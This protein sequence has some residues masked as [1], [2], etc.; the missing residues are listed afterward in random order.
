MKDSKRSFSTIFSDYDFYLLGEGK[1]LKSYEKLG[2]HRREI[3][4]I[5]GVNFA[6]WAPNA[7]AASVVGSFNDW[8]REANPMHKHYP[9]GIWETFIPGI[10]VGALYKYSIET[11]EGISE[12][13]DPVGFYAEVPPHNASTFVELDNYQWGDDEWLRE[14]QESASSWGEK[15]IS[16]YE[17]HFGSWARSASEPERLPTYREIADQLVDYVKKMGY[18]HIEFLPLAE[19]PLLA[20]WGYQVI[21]MYSLTSRYGSPEDFMYLVDQCHKNHI[22]VIM[23][24]VP[25]HFPKDSYGLRRFDGTA[26]YEHEDPRRGEHREWGTLVFNYSRN[27][28]RNYLISNALFWI[29]K[30]HIDGLRVDAVASM[31]YLDYNRG[32]NEWIP[33]EDGGRENHEAVDFLKELN[34]QLHHEYPGVLTIAEE[35][36]TWPGVSHAVA[37]GGLGFSMKWNMGWMHD[38]LDYCREDPLFR[39]FHH[40]QLTFSLMYAFSEAFVLPIS[41][42]EVVHGKGTFIANAPGDLWQKFALARLFYSYMWTHPGKKLLF[43]G[44]DFGQ[45]KEWNFDKGLDWELLKYDSTHGGLQ[46]CVADLNKIYAHEK[47][48]YQFDF[49]WRGFVWINCSYWEESVFAYLR[50]AEDPRDQLLVVLNF[51]PVPRKK[52]FGVPLNVDYQEI[53][54]SDSPFYGG[55]GTGNGLLKSEKIEWDNQPYSIEVLLPP[56]GASIFKPVWDEKRVDV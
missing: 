46:R 50:R 45:W 31:L 41:H 14:R 4:G 13:S 12:R 7:T 19:H 18:T 42:D 5:K 34:V 38:A 29:D 56:L 39:K 20:S 11:C 26:L 1:L 30:Y 24:W 9:S 23:D 40:N 43:M 15:P 54:C 37:D 8:S 28:V 53:F 49:D 27:E 21:G 48:L 10:E 33:N 16:I 55:S 32:S 47:A 36:T 51:T 2:A 17:V 35:S 6:V 3:D 44:C 22:G 52:R 25:A